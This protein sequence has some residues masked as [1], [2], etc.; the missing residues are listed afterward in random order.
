MPY[1]N[2]VVL[3]TFDSNGTNSGSGGTTYN[4]TN[5]TTTI[6]STD[7]LK[8]AGSLSVPLNTPAGAGVPIMTYNTGTTGITISFWI[9][10]S[11]TAGGNRFIYSSKAL[12]EGGN[13]SY[14]VMDSLWLN[15][16]NSVLYYSKGSITTKTV[17]DATYYTDNNWHHFVVV[18]NGG[19]NDTAGKIYVDN[20]LIS[21]TT[22]IKIG[23]NID[24]QVWIGGC[25]Y[26]PA[27]EDYGADGN[28]DDFRIYNYVADATFVSYLY[29]LGSNTN[30][31][32]LS[33]VAVADLN[34]AGASVGQ[35]ISM[36]KP[37]ADLIAAGATVTQLLAAGIPLNQLVNYVQ[38]LDLS[39]TSNVIKKTYVNN[40]VDLSGDMIVRNDGTLTVDGDVLMGGNLVIASAGV[41]TS[42]GFIPV[43]LPNYTRHPINNISQYYVLP[44]LSLP[45]N[46]SLMLSHISIAALANIIPVDAVMVGST[47]APTDD[48][49]PANVG[50][51][52]IQPRLDGNS[53]QIQ[54]EWILGVSRSFTNFVSTQMALIKFRL[55]GTTP[56]VIQVAARYVDSSHPALYGQ[57]VL[58]NTNY[59]STA[60]DMNKAYNGG[61]ANTIYRIAKL[62]IT[63]QI[64]FNI[65]TPETF[66]PDS[67]LTD[68][69]TSYKIITVSPGSPTAIPSL[70]INSLSEIELVN[71]TMT[72]A[73]VTV[74]TPG[75]VAYPYNVDTNGTA[76]VGNWLIGQYESAP[77]ITKVCRIAITL[78]G[79]TPYIVQLSRA[80]NIN[81]AT[82]TS[83]ALG[84]G[85]YT[86]SGTDLARL[87]VN[88]AGGGIGSGPQPGTGYSVT[89]VSYKTISLSNNQTPKLIINDLSLNGQLF[90]GKD[91]IQNRGNVSIQGNV[92]IGGDLAINKQFSGNFADGIIPTSA[93][94]NYPSSSGG[95]VT[96]TG[97]VKT[98]GDVSFNGTTLQVSSGST[99]KVN[100][101]LILSD[102]TV[103]NSYDNNIA[104]GTFAQSNV[105]FKD[106][107]FN[108][109]IVLGAAT[110]TGAITVT[111]DYR[112]KENIEDLNSSFTL[113]SL[114]PVQYDN[115]LSGNHEY[116]VI[117]HEL[118]SAY[119]F[120]VQGEKDGPEYQ[121]VSY[122]GL[123]GV[124]V[125]EV[126]TL[127]QNLDV[128]KTRI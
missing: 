119:P 83:S 9:K 60:A 105:V 28:I 2:P 77:N 85:N 84:N 48:T 114:T 69:F 65:T 5:G 80:Y 123:I 33:S 102:Q 88:V 27:S 4:I 46:D 35:L 111:S 75:C 71:A 76:L 112:I 25:Y 52:V 37:V 124:M 73:N 82:D 13:T 92:S 19:A 78:T 93:I 56:S 74:L 126:K 113:D 99:I 34:A 12:S 91:S 95:D 43:T 44:L 104:S 15:A 53:A 68:S 61:T 40:F 125:N 79:T 103:L 108:S 11:S 51:V 1:A 107:R 94:I 128:L 23:N 110:V 98:L 127:K 45:E 42:T 90:I 72:G 49:A 24:Q 66:I 57:S 14:T 58:G 118:Q 62:K 120:L 7:K 70:S 6:S 63:H 121:R 39:A 18:Y 41:P 122:P 50:T 10:F 64:V 26:G 29:K 86:S 96:I 100:G 59:T 109:V 54:G 106:S 115:I 22:T 17:S 31:A 3:Y 38:W 87:F 30:V 67:S 89:S 81:Y 116:G 55:H 32:T 47:F 117:A 97:K 101:N 21:S 20:A 16:T 36:G 8:G